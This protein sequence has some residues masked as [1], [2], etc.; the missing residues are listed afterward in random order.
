M[1][2]LRPLI[3]LLLRPPLHPAAAPVYLSPYAPAPSVPWS[4]LISLLP[5]CLTRQTHANVCVWLCRR[6]CPRCNTCCNTCC[7]TG[8]ATP[9]ACVCCLW[10]PSKGLLQ[11][12]PGHRGNRGDRG[13]SGVPSLTAALPVRP[14]HDQAQRLLLQEGAEE[15]RFALPSSVAHAACPYP[16]TAFH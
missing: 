15:N 16:S 4:L 2:L 10:R 7:N 9:S 8:A 3:S 14:Q 11:S 12:P 6:A 1:S 5:Y 13:T